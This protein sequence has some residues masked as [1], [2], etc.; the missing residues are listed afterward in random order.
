MRKFFIVGCGRSG[1]T[2]LQQALNRHSRIVIPPETGYFIDFLGHTRRGQTQHLRRI[3]ADLGLDLA[4]PAHRLRHRA[5]SVA[6]YDAIAE[7]YVRRLRRSDI[8]CFGDKSPHHIFALRRIAT[9]LPDA[10]FILMY[11][12]GRDVALSLSRVPWAPDD[13]FVNFAI[14]LRCY[15]WHQWAKAANLD[16]MCVKYEDFVTRPETELRRIAA[17][18]T[19]DYEAPM[20]QGYGNQEGIPAWEK[21]WKARAVERISPTRVRLWRE[22]LSPDDVALLERWG[23]NALRELG[24]E[25]STPQP[26]RLPLPFF[27]RLW[28]RHTAWRARC[29][30]KL[31]KKEILGR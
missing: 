12:D 30:V 24:Y 8:T 17:F 27:P 21:E 29:A 10:R 26:R 6:Y 5:E 28:Y 14:W 11:R 9:W 25:L 3:N 15:R 31:L 16:L 20:A 18:L 4:P 19:V 2:V 23:G 22:E 7:A 13:L 1:T